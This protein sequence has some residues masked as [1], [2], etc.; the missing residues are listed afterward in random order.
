MGGADQGQRRQRRLGRVLI[1]PKRLHIR[2]IKD[3]LISSGL[4]RQDGDFREK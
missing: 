3:S 2:L 1:A 4:V